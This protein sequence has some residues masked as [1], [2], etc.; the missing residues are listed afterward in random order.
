[1]FELHGGL[2]E[3]CELHGVE[4]WMNCVNYMEVCKE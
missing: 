4:V 3:L 1:L 2:D